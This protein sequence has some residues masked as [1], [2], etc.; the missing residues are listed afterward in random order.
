MDKTTIKFWSGLNTIGGNIAEV[1]Y[2][3][4]RVIFDFGRNYNPADVLLTSA[5]GRGKK[6]VQ[7][8]LKLGILPKIDGIYSD[9]DLGENPFDIEAFQSSSLNTAIL[10]SHLHLDHIGSIDTIDEYLP[11]YMSCESKKMFEQLMLIG[12]SPFRNLEHIF[13]VNANDQIKVGEILITAIPVDHDAHGSVSFLIETPDKKICYSGDLRM[14]GNSP[15]LNEKW[16]EIIKNKKVDLLLLEATTFFPLND[17]YRENKPETFSEPDI[18]NEILNVV[19]NVNG[20]VF[21]NYYHRNLDRLFHLFSV[22][23]KSNRKLVLEFPTAQIAAT[24]FKDEDFKILKDNSDTDWKNQLTRKFQMIDVEQMNKNPELY[25]VQNSFENVLNLI[26]YKRDDSIYIHSNGTPL[27]SFDPSYSS[28]LSFLENNNIGVKYY[29]I[30]TSGHATNEAILDIIDETSPKKL[31]IW[32]SLAP[33]CVIPRNP[34][35][36]ILRPLLDLW[37]EV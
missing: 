25:L 3:N 28:L 37:Y 34:N 17:T 29:N 21:F 23:K 16:M 6:R 32:H 35:Q 18:P 15:H 14:H 7:D 19:D 13:A 4:D 5:K 24:F 33:E 1:R 11:I 36:L 8:M 22:A 2:N 27:G 26:D 20:F 12:E 9:S 10:I 31:V 30:S